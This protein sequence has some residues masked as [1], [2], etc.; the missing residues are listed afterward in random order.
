MRVVLNGCIENWLFQHEAASP[1][2]WAGAISCVITFHASS[3]RVAGWR[4]RILYRLKRSLTSV[5]LHRRLQLTSSRAG[6]SEQCCRTVWL[7]V[8]LF[9]TTTASRGWHM[10]HSVY[11]ASLIRSLQLGGLANWGV[12]FVIVWR[13]KSAS[14]AV[15]YT[16]GSQSVGVILLLIRSCETGVA[17]GLIHPRV[18][19]ART[20][21]C[22]AIHLCMVILCLFTFKLVQ[23]KVYY[24]YLRD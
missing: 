7:L 12:A 5:Q 14:G 10:M 9:N 13:I 4:P 20:G 8:I 16:R 18:T 15:R 1:C 17:L 23:G 11:G 24:V 19:T 21:K 3:F 2:W 22:S 6:T